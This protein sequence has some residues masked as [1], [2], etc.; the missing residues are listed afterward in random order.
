M[1]FPAASSSSSAGSAS[2]SL[3]LHTGTAD[4]SLSTLGDQRHLGNAIGGIVASGSAAEGRADGTLNLQIFVPD[5]KMQKC[6]CVSLD[7][8]VWDIKF[9]LLRSL[10]Q[11]LDKEF[12]FGLFLPPCDGRAGKFLLEDRQI[13][14]YPFHDCVPYVELKYKKRVYKM[15]RLDEKAL[16]VVHSRTNLRKVAEAVQGRNATKVERLC[17]QGLDPN[18]HDVHGESLLTLAAGIEGNRAVIVQLVGGGAHLDFRNAEG[19]T[20][21]HKAAFLSIADNLRTLL[22]LG[23]SPNY[24]D[25]I[26]LTPL[27]YNMLNTDSNSEVAQMLLAEAADLDVVDMHGNTAMH[28]ACKNGLA[29]HVELMIY[30][31]ADTNARNVN[32]NTPL[33]VCAV[34]GRVDCAQVLLYRGADPTL[35]NRQGQSPVHVAQFVGTLA[36]AEVIQG[37]DPRNIVPFRDVPLLNPR[38]RLSSRQSN[39]PDHSLLRRRSLS[40]CSSSST[41]ASVH[42]HRFSGHHH[43]PASPCLSLASS[44]VMGEYGTLRRESLQQ[45]FVFEPNIPRILVIPRGRNGFGFI[46]RGAKDSE[47][48][49]DGAADCFRPSRA[50]PALQFFEGIVPHG[51]AAR[52]GL[53]AGDFLLEVNGVDVRSASHE[54][55]VKL[56]HQSGDPI[57]LKVIT[58]MEQSHYASPGG[59]L[60][61][62]N[63]SAPRHVSFVPP[64]PPQRDPSTALSYGRAVGQPTAQ[65][66][67]SDLPPPPVVFLPSSS[68]PC[69]SSA[70]NS[71]AHSLTR[72]RAPPSASPPRPP[73][74]PPPVPPPFADQI[75][76]AS[77]K[78]G[79]ASANRRISAAE[80]ENLMT[81]QPQ[82]QNDAILMTAPMAM[83]NTSTTV[84]VEGGPKKFTSVNEMK[85]RKQQN[86]Q[87]QQFRSNC[88]SANAAECCAIPLKNSN[89]SPDLHGA[90]EFRTV[91]RPKTPPPPPPAQ[92]VAMARQKNHRQ[93]GAVQQT[94]NSIVQLPSAA[95]V[96]LPSGERQMK[97]SQEKQSIGASTIIV[98][99]HHDS[100]TTV[101][102]AG[103]SQG[104]RNGTGTNA[105]P[106]APPPPPPPN[107]LRMP[108]SQKKP[109]PSAEENASVHCASPSFSSAPSPAKGAGGGTADCRGVSAEALQSVRL[110]SIA[111][112][113]RNATPEGSANGPTS[114]A[115]NSASKSEKVTP[116]ADFDSD[117]RS[118]LAKRRSKV[119]QKGGNEAGTSG[120]Q[121]NGTMPSST[122]NTTS[123]NNDNSRSNGNGVTMVNRYNA[124][125]SLRESVM[126]NVAAGAVKGVPGS[127][128]KSTP[129]SHSPTGAFTGCKKDSGYTSSRTSLEPSDYG[130]TEQQNQNHPNHHHSQH[131]LVPP[132][133]PVQHRVSVLSQQM[134]AAASAA[135][136]PVSLRG[137]SAPPAESQPQPM[138]LSMPNDSPSLSRRAPLLLENAVKIPAVDYD[139]QQPTTSCGQGT[140]SC[141]SDSGQGSSAGSED[142]AEGI[143][144]VSAVCSSPS[145]SFNGNS[146]LSAGTFKKKL[147]ENWDFEDVAE[148]LASLGMGEYAKAFG[149]TTGRELLRFDRTRFTALGVTRIGHRQ[150]MERSLQSFS[151]RSD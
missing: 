57:T 17:A 108:L 76:C 10:P 146:S 125:L 61:R 95:A 150:T 29:K 28:Q 91:L 151:R 52:A 34:N 117:L 98:Q 68:V 113:E 74:P 131:S 35:L 15:L 44:S 19:Q 120:Q 73:S 67:A 121:N 41:M 45:H 54:R 37:H 130:D 36:V 38:R 31:G 118:A 16:N 133:L 114:S 48:A 43:P 42:Q 66:C 97:H 84:A 139:D 93:D 27:Y 115:S 132:S 21:M 8:I 60:G 13:R 100:P 87:Q 128:V 89:S 79:R 78:L 53:L 145:P 103:I 82:Q 51:M 47:S 94:A 129:N 33:H 50:N 65:F 4:D 83:P 77:V 24:R 7:E 55:V 69:C 62:R 137:L 85:R 46:L 26:G 99:V 140:K 14:E 20:C 105:P 70:V 127:A 58:V 11:K 86:A 80:L 9:R 18:H 135:Q 1:H 111:R 143:V 147:V 110:R 88:S 102:S 75:R 148:W 142:S 56:I 106:P 123:E 12:N 101:N 40:H 59:T 25:L 112:D 6:L 3:S 22:E 96:T 126:E 104:G 63:H 149:R 30:Y 141:S 23:A 109:G 134:E 144:V 71:S 136:S 72:P 32:G 81:N 49:S 138:P 90:A 122:C 107:W 119:Q 2:P 116:P 92:K 39:A 124:G 5:I 64:P